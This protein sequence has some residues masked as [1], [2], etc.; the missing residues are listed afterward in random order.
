MSDITLGDC[1]HDLTRRHIRRDGPTKGKW[2]DALLDQLDAAVTGIGNKGGK[3]T[4]DPAAPVNIRAMDVQREVADTVRKEARERGEEDQRPVREILVSWADDGA[5]DQ[6]LTRV[7]M[8]IIDQIKEAIEPQVKPIPLDQACPDPSCGKRRVRQQDETG[9]WVKRPALLVH[10]RDEDGKGVAISKWSAYC[11]ACG[12][13]W[14]GT[15]ELA[16]LGR[17][18]TEEDVAA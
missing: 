6:H 16:W 5:S 9:A 4:N 18:L 17:M 3:S 13:E 12:R 15:H 10:C 8:G 11:A 14:Q 7:T 2:E 1:V